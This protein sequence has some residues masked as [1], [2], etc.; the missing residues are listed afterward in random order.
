MESSLI[1]HATRRNVESEGDETKV[2]LDTPIF[3]CTLAFPRMPMILHVFESGHRL[4]IQRCIES[5]T[6]RF[7]MVLPSRDTG[8]PGTAGVMPYGTMLEIRGVQ[9]LPDGR[10]LVETI[11]TH[12]FR[13]RGAETVDG[14]T[15][16]KTQRSVS[17]VIH[18]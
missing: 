16:A 18:T 10:S 15:M 2:W 11:G 5:P 1:N 14:Y 7:G 13:L 4:M 8:A 12:R 9:M 6:P 3:V 17:L